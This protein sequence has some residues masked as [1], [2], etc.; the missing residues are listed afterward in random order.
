MGHVHGALRQKKVEE[1]VK[2][3]SKMQKRAA[4]LI[5]DAAIGERGEMLFRRLDFFLFLYFFLLYIQYMTHSLTIPNYS[6]LLTI[7]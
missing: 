1:N 5:V 7:D 4:R 6:M 3:V 2:R